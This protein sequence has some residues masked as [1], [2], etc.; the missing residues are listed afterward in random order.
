MYQPVV[1]LNKDMLVIAP[2]LFIGSRPERNLLAVVSSNK[3]HEYSK[4]VNDLENLMVTDLESV[5]ADDAN[6]QIV[7]HKKLGGTLPDIDFAICDKSTNSALICELKWFAAADSAKEVY[8]KEDEITH[9][10]QQVE[11][12][13]AYAMRD[14]QAFCKQVFNVDDGVDIDLFCCVVAK[15]NIRTQ[16][17]YIPV[18][19]LK[20]ITEL[21]SSNSLNSVFHT[22]RNHEY[23]VALPDNATITH[24]EIEYGG[25]T[26]RIP[27]IR[28]D[29]FVI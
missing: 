5:I 7:K 3:D 12:I 10:C 13:M 26:F 2:M 29:S 28:F 25:Y 20:R 21:F 4:E 9:G 1:E 15:H 6:V 14:K 23:E 22:I 19:D 11:S 18:I 16:N 17:R 8:A 27:A 24:Q